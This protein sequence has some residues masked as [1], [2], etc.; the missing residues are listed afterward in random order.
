MRNHQR[1]HGDR[2]FSKLLF[3]ALIGLASRGSP[4]QAVTL[5]NATSSTIDAKPLIPGGCCTRWNFRTHRLVFMA[6]GAGGYYRV[7]TCR[8]DGQDRRNV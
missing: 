4:S 8:P 5:D 6:P 3:L 7:F 2:L 1:P